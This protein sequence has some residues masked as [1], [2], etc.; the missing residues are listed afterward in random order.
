MTTNKNSRVF[1]QPTTCPECGSH[2]RTDYIRGEV[3]CSE[4]GLVVDEVY[5]DPGP[6]WRAFDA[7]DFKERTRT[8]AP[9]TYMI[10]DKGLSTFIDWRNSDYNG[11]V[12]SSKASGQFHRLRKMHKRAGASGDEKRL[13]YALMQI[14][15]V[16]SSLGLPRNIRE[17]AAFM[18]RKVSESGGL[19]GRNIDSIAAAAIYAACKMSGVPRT[20]DEIAKASKVSKKAIGRNYRFLRGKLG[21]KFKLTSPQD[22]IPRFCSEC[23][24]DSDVRNKAIEIADSVWNDMSTSGKEPRC[25]AA[26]AIYIAACLCRVSVTQKQIAVVTGVTE[27]TIRNTYREI[28]K[29]LGG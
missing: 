23:G 20:L 12:L 3:V 17:E 16:A 2:V 5:I 29:R 4:C 10:H 1:R 11:K 18:Y 26:A 21:L 27:V 28:V 19:K 25:V 9:S 15:S 14:D 13:A 22:Y 7:V 6:E 24:F 8:G